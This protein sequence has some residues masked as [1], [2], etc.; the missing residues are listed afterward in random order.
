MLTV[1]EMLNVLLMEQALG[2][3]MRPDDCPTVV[4]MGGHVH[5]RYPAPPP[6]KAAEPTVESPEPEKK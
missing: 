2:G 3:P 5:P 6:P 4:R 1:E